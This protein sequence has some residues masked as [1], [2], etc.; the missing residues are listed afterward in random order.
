MHKVRSVNV[1]L[2]HFSS[3]P[4]IHTLPDLEV[5]TMSVERV[6]K[7]TVLGAGSDL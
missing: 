7:M 3:C 6:M 4:A 2:A 1:V 5:T